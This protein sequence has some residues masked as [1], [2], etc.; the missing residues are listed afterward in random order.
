MVLASCL[1]EILDE[2]F[3]TKDNELESLHVLHSLDEVAH[4]TLAL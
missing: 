3:S 2:G 4:R 1:H